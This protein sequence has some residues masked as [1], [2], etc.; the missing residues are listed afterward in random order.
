MR[1]NKSSQD[2]SI[3]NIVND[4]DN[5]L[6]CTLCIEIKLDLYKKGKMD[7]TSRNALLNPHISLW[8]ILIHIFH[9]QV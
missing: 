5:I 1:Q 3:D 6:G 9:L 4:K 8:G 7:R 2:K